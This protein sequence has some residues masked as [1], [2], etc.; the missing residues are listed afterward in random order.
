MALHSE[1]IINCTRTEGYFAANPTNSRPSPV[2][3][4]PTTNNTMHTQLLA[5]KIIA[6]HS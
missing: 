6:Y 1:N 3:T 4:K 5:D 2:N